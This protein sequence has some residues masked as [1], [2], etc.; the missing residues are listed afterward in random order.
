MVDAE[1]VNLQSIL[2]GVNDHTPGQGDMKIYPNPVRN[3]VTVETSQSFVNSMLSVYN[4]SGQ[5]VLTQKVVSSKTQLDLIRF[6]KGVYTIRIVNKDKV[7]VGKIV[8]E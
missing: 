5:E 4:I 3:T 8:K 7:E 2:V 6:A 1:K